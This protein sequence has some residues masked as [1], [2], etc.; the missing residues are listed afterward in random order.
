MPY[1]IKQPYFLALYL[2]ADHELIISE[3]DYSIIVIR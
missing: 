3:Y 2:Q 1:L